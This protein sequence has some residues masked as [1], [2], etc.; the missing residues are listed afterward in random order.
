M[1][2]ES[3]ESHRG[4]YVFFKPAPSHTVG[5]PLCQKRGSL[6]V[7]P[8]FSSSLGRP[9]FFFLS[10]FLFFPCLFHSFL[11]IVI[12]ILFY[13]K[14]PGVLAC[15][16]FIFALKLIAVGIAWP[17]PLAVFTMCTSPS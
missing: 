4:I 16:F 5:L 11:F 3:T 2:H 9:V 12:F 13:C 15:I 10:I 1:I 8:C 17:N 7:V 6:S 14:W